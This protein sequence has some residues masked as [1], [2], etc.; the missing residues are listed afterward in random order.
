MPRHES[1]IGKAASRRDVR[2]LVRFA[3][4]YSED[5]PAID[6]ALCDLVSQLASQGKV[7]DLVHVLFLPERKPPW[8]AAEAAVERLISLGPEVNQ[9]VL[10]A[11]HFAEDPV[12][13]RAA[14]VLAATGDAEKATGLRLAVGRAGRRILLA[15]GTVMILLGAGFFIMCMH[16]SLGMQV[17]DPG[18]RHVYLLVGL[19]S[20]I[21][22][23]VGVASVVVGLLRAVE[24][25]HVAWGSGGGA[26]DETTQQAERPG[27][28]R[29]LVLRRAMQAAIPATVLVG[30]GLLCSA[31]LALAGVPIFD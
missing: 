16:L 14:R 20:L 31:V 10:S 3:H 13:E 11:A 22:P 12:K 1:W 28:R 4:L 9:S 26:G 21:I 2:E 5:D 19:V 30:T 15:M 17:E 23:L 8:A 18:L 6:A 7:Q 24:R 25:S 27:R 29:A